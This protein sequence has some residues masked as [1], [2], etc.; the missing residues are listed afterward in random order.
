MDK[1]IGMNVGRM[2]ERERE[3]ESERKVLSLPSCKRDPV[4]LYLFDRPRFARE[5]REGEEDG[6]MK[7]EGGRK[8]EGRANRGDE[9]SRIGRGSKG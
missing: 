1:Q 5:E 4:T 3:V 8:E 7:E 6:G 9:G 2:E